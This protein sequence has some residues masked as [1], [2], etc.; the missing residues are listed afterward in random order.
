MV[1]YEERDIMVCKSVLDLPEIQGR[2]LETLW[3]DVA[4]T[5]LYVEM[6]GDRHG[7]YHDVSDDGTWR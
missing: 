4:V 7:F 5:H 6:G 1:L 2:T 3:Q